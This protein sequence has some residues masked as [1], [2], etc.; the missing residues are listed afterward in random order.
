ML[1]R[2]VIVVGAAVLVI[3]GLSAAL[4]RLLRVERPRRGPEA[5]T[6]GARS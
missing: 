2:T 1:K 5:A 4:E 3:A 6:R